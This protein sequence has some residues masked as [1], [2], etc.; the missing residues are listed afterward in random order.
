MS[1]Q[2]REN[3]HGVIERIVAEYT[4]GDAPEHWDIP[5]LFERIDQIVALSFGADDI[6]VMGMER[7]DLVDTITE[8]ALEAY[9][10]KEE[11][12]SPELMRD[13][14]R[15]V[16]LEI[17][18]ERWREHLNDMDYLREGIHLRGFAEVQP[19]VAYKNEGFAMFGELM[20]SI[21]DEFANVIYH[22]ELTDEAARERA[23]EQI[24]GQSRSSNT[25]QFNYTSNDAPEY[26]VGAAVA[27]NMA[28]AD[29]DAPQG[30][31]GS[32][33]GVIPR[34]AQVTSTAAGGKGVPAGYDP[35]GNPMSRNQ[36]C[37][38]GSGKKFKNC[39]GK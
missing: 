13:L 32:A 7:H 5:E 36:P 39:H 14:E 6:N 1:E 25:Q 26:G 8:E 30:S 23:Q 35:D 15:H 11:E 27:A 21:W 29:I 20:D 28:E 37:W 12:L 31:G 17:I 2:A 3:M 19:I 34:P 4:Q 22:F 24:L 33:P 16:L 38:C 10:E 18:D 9:E